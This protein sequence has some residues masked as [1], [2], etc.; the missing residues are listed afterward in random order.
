MKNKSLKSLLAALILLSSL[1]LADASLAQISKSSIQNSEQLVEDPD[2]KLS[3]KELRKKYPIG[4]LKKKYGDPEKYYDFC[5]TIDYVEPAE[6][7]PPKN[8]V[9]N[10]QAIKYPF[11]TFSDSEIRSV[12]VN[13]KVDEFDF[14]IE[15]IALIALEYFEKT[16]ES[17][18]TSKEKLLRN[19]I[20][21]D[22]V[23][24]LFK[25]LRN[26]IVIKHVRYN[27]AKPL[28]NSQKL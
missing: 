10:F 22:Q 9:C 17:S 13:L 2:L 8:L 21:S 5:S 4:W 23:T 20:Y 19:F 12:V 28:G 26:C 15:Q 7:A 11:K 1:M 16:P 24:T 14:R 18:L 25:K 6:E 27:C 3:I